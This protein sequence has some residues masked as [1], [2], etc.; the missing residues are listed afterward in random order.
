MN[1]GRVDVVVRGRVAIATLAGELDISNVAEIATEI[2]EAVS[3][4]LVGLCLDL[5]ELRYID[6]AGVRMIFDLVGRLEAC[7]QGVAIVVPPDAQVRRL[8]EVTNLTS[9]V[10]VCPVVDECLAHLEGSVEDLL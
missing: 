3:N 7:R 5:G 9:A 8:V 6:S 1:E 4:E 10:T 2:R